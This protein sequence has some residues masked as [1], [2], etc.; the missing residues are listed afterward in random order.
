MNEWFFFSIA[1]LATYRLSRLIAD[2][3]GPWSVF[4]KIRDA[5]PEQTNLR[6]G[7]ECIMC[8]SVWAAIPITAGLVAGGAIPLAF[9]PLWWLAL[10]SIT[11]LIRKWEQKR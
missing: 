5:T 7:I 10:S 8:V 1:A 3:E 11:V 4:S 9:S 2:E 6:R